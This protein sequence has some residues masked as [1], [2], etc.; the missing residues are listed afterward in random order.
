MISGVGFG[1]VVQFQSE[2][3]L[4]D[5]CIASIYF[6][7]P[8]ISSPSVTPSFNLLPHLYSSF[9]S[10]LF[11][12]NRAE[13]IR[14]SLP[15]SFS[16]PFSLFLSFHPLLV[17]ICTSLLP[18]IQPTLYVSIPFQTD[19]FVRLCHTHTQIAEWRT[20]CRFVFLFRPHSYKQHVL[21]LTYKRH[22]WN[23]QGNTADLWLLPVDC[24]AN[25]RLFNR[26]SVEGVTH[27]DR[28]WC[29]VFATGGQW[30]M[31]SRCAN[32][33]TDSASCCRV[34]NTH[35]HAERLCVQCR[36]LAMHGF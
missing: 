35:L 27:R 21:T 31:D 5:T 32:A 4:K 30:N 13:M 3:L 29:C 20:C 11:T 25:Y 12:W 17:P 33:L 28:D 10:F 36:M 19:Q 22:A 1:Q 16:F 15:S 14:I 34:W 2:P 6:I 7:S 23:T 9:T 24:G 8:D 18:P 26:P